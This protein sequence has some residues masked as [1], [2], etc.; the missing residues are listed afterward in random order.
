MK[1]AQCFVIFASAAV[2]VHCALCARHANSGRTNPAVA[3]VQPRAERDPGD[4]QS[5]GP[6]M[7]P[8][9]VWWRELVYIGVRNHCV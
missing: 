7:R 3:V 8:G 2:G 4:R 1:G 9:L 5:R 6:K